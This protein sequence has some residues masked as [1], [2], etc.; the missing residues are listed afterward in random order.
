MDDRSTGF[1]LR[2][3]W[4]VLAL[5]IALV[6]ACWAAPACRADLVIEAPNLT[7]APGSSGSFD[8]LITSTSGSFEVASDTVELSLN[9]LSGVSFTGV[10]IN[11]VTP[12]IYGAES[13][14]LFGS[15]FSF[16]TFPGTTFEVIDFLF[17]L[18][19]QPINSGDVFGLVN[20]SYSV[21]AGATP[22]ASGSLTFGADTSLADAAGNNVPFTSPSGSI[23]IQSAVPEPASVILLSIGCA[24]VVLRSSRK[25]PDTVG[26]VE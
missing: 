5:A 1:S 12:Y 24:A 6:A 13:A 10:S 15:T 19:A 9:G 8:V 18:G 3:P 21:D 26:K 25:R 16:S 22:G 7:V 20:V 11:T 2:R 17:T 4:T 14:T 23:T